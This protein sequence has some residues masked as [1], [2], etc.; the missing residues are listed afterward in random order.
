[1]K[2]IYLIANKERGY[3]A[4]V[5]RLVATAV[6][7]I[8][9][10]MFIFSA[11]RWLQFIVAPLAFCTAMWW[12]ARVPDEEERVLRCHP[13][14]DE[15]TENLEAFRSK[16]HP[17]ILQCLSALDLNY[18]WLN[19]VSYS[20]IMVWKPG[21]IGEPKPAELE[22]SND[23]NH[24]L[25]VKYLSD[26]GMWLRAENVPYLASLAP[27][28]KASEKGS[29]TSA[30]VNVAQPADTASKEV[31]KH[32]ATT[33]A[34]AQQTVSNSAQENTSASH[35]EEA[36]SSIVNDTGIPEAA[37]RQSCTLVWEKICGMI[38]DLLADAESHGDKSIIFSWPKGIRTAFEGDMLAGMMKD[39]LSL[40]IRTDFDKSEYEIFLPAN[41]EETVAES[42]TETE[43]EAAPVEA[44]IPSDPD[45]MDSFAAA[46]DASIEA[47]MPPMTFDDMV[48]PPPEDEVGDY[49]VFD[50]DV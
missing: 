19:T 49:N 22:L 8:I 32:E 4:L 13:N 36:S 26:N 12:A 18:D 47:A 20:E 9:A 11:P 34:P 38:A 41:E 48:A 33:P 44:I 31:E 5:L 24:V 16:V 15:A 17:E 10:M 43:A 46:E 29:S 37:L 1:M 35:S 30:G 42:S 14:P 40:E 25:A 3:K 2:A 7:G 6:L 28:E 50:S 27:D 45:A 23:Y 39:A 21:Y